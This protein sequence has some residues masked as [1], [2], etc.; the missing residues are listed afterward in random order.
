MRNGYIAC[1]LA[2]DAAQI[3]LA[4]DG[5]P[6]ASIQTTDWSVFLGIEDPQLVVDGACFCCEYPATRRVCTA[7]LKK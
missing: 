4:E 3:V 1:G 6:P 5:L 2:H 7:P